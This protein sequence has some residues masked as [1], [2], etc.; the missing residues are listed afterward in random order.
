MILCR[1]HL[2]LLSILSLI[3]DGRQRAEAQRVKDERTAKEDAFWAQVAAHR[4]VDPNAPLQSQTPPS[5]PS[6]PPLKDAADKEEVDGINAVL[7]NTTNLII[8]NVK[9]RAEAR[10]VMATADACVSEVEW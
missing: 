7:E 2:F 8:D 6:K 4:R 10:I 1:D 5:P 3:L 9:A